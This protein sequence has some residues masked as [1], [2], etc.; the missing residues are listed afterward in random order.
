MEI[1]HQGIRRPN[2]RLE[3]EE[4]FS[5]GEKLKN[6]SSVYKSIKGSGIVYFALIK[7]LESLFRKCFIQPGFR[8][9][10]IMGSL[11]PS[12]AKKVQN[13]FMSSDTLV[14][15]TNAFGMGIDK[16]DLRY[17]IHAEIPGSMESYYQEIGRAGRD[18]KDALC[19]ML[20][21]QDDLS[22]H[23]DFIKCVQP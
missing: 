19:R 3:A 21:S 15:A 22:I 7:T 2:L 23:M 6:I 10:F 8:I 9:S 20:Y 17:V 11:H 18:G 16:P 4:C 1:I 13:H 12:S 14:L 5:D